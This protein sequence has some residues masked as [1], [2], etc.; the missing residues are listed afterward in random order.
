MLALLILHILCMIVVS[1]FGSLATRRVIKLKSLD[2]LS[3]SFSIGRMNCPVEFQGYVIIVST[4]LFSHFM[5]KWE[6]NTHIVDDRCAGVS[7]F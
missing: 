6:D 1:S 5:V 2:S 4:L 7:F 3:K